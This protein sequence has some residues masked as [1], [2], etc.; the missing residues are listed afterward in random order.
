MAGCGLRA[1]RPYLHSDVLR[2]A[3]NDNDNLVAL[4]PCYRLTNLAET[5]V[6]LTVGCL[7]QGTSTL[8]ST[9]YKYGGYSAA[10]SQTCPEWLLLR[11]PTNV[12][13]SVG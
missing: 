3:E 9:Q 4:R 12:I 6:C 5:G 2:V 13:V 11:I 7:G 10:F 1:H 8:D